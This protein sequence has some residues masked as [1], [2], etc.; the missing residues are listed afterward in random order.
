LILIL[1]AAPYSKPLRGAKDRD[2][3]YEVTAPTR[4]KTDLF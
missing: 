2:T 3:E 1:K 4:E